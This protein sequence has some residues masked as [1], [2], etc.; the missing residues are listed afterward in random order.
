MCNLFCLQIL[1]DPEIV[2]LNYDELIQKNKN[3]E[4]EVQN[5][6][7]SNQNLQV[8]LESSNKRNL[9]LQNY[10][11]SVDERVPETLYI[12]KVIVHKKKEMIVKINKVLVASRKEGGRLYRGGIFLTKKQCAVLDKTNSDSEF[13]NNLLVCLFGR[14]ILKSHSLTGR[15][16]NRTKG[17]P[18]PALDK[19]RI[20]LLYGIK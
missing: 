6:G 11:V 5:L 19:E 2:T 8:Q 20:N 12:D 4:L 14:E 7:I 16:S 9:A 13:I 18:K 15:R 1:E 10:L 3:L 17:L